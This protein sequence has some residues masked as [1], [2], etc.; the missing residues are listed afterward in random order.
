MC[1]LVS[2]EI[3]VS[4][5]SLMSLPHLV[6][7]PLVRLPLVLVG[8]S[9][10]R[11]FRLQI[12]EGARE[13]VIFLI[14]FPHQTL[15]LPLIITGKS[16]P[17]LAGSNS[18]TSRFLESALTLGYAW[19]SGLMCLFLWPNQQILQRELGPRVGRLT[20]THKINQSADRSAALPLVN[21]TAPHKN[22]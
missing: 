12:R 15:K 10:R 2:E 11:V 3:V 17:R 9:Q 16:L 21:V 4:D 14:S 20:A 18:K 19:C 8:L 5:C 6:Q 1:C 7:A 13:R 22:R